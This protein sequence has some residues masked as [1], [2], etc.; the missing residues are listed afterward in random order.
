MLLFDWVWNEL[1]FCKV[2]FG[3]DIVKV[4]FYVGMIGLD[5]DLCFDCYM[6]GV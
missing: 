6:V 5:L 3:Y 2:N 1:V 4:C